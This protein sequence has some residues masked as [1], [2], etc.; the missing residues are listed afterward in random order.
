[1]PPS[2]QGCGRQQAGVAV[3]PAIV[4]ANADKVVYEIT[5]DLPD[6]GLGNNVV[7]PDPLL[8]GNKEALDIGADKAA[9]ANPVVATEEGQRYPTRACRSAVGNQPYNAYTP[10][11]TFLQLGVTRAHRSVIEAIQSV[12]MSKNKQ[13]HM[14][15]QLP[16]GD[17]D[18][19][20]IEH[21]TDTALL[22]ESE[23]EIMVWRYIM[24]QYNLKPGL[25][26]FGAHGA[27]AVVKELTQLHIMDTWKPMH[28]SQL[29]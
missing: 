9:A 28:P 1:M 20:N 21:I 4:E 8:Q 15:I 3:P 14:S 2:H 16:N 23:D 29:G 10:R 12:G 22:T 19:N 5:F 13:L 27:A 24:M 7:P 26:K 17:L 25:R 6:A 11:M 18:V